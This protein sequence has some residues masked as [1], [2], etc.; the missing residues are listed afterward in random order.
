MAIKILIA[1]FILF[2]WRLLTLFIVLK[3]ELLQLKDYVSL[4]LGHCLPFFFLLLL[5]FNLQNGDR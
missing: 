2:L 4:Y 5:A 3:L 1:I